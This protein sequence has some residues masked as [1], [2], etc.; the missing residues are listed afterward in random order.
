[1]WFQY[2]QDD[3]NRNGIRGVQITF[4]TSSFGRLLEGITSETWG[5]IVLNSSTSINF[6]TTDEDVTWRWLGRLPKH[7]TVG[8]DYNKRISMF[9][10]RVSRLEHVVEVLDHVGA[11]ELS[12]IIKENLMGAVLRAMVRESVLIVHNI[13]LLRSLI[14]DTTEEQDLTVSGLHS[15]GQHLWSSGSVALN[16]V[17]DSNEYS[18]ALVN[19][20]GLQKFSSGAPALQWSK[21]DLLLHDAYLQTED[22]R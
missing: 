2:A 1:M 22:A 5:Q 9:D 16:V 14:P 12:R 21:V 15:S 3:I 13:R 19:L 17:K 20:R 11:H 8:L 4:N 10:V 18:L 7:L 6:R